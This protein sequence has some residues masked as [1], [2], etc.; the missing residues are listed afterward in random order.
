MRESTKLPRVYLAGKI[1][2]NDWRHDVVS[3]LRGAWGEDLVGGAALTD[4]EP[5]PVLA[6][7]VLNGRADYV[8]PYFVSCD[9]GCTHNARSHAVEGGC[10]TLAE[11][12][13]EY[14]N[15]VQIFSRCLLS[16]L[17]AD[18]VMGWINSPDCYGTLVE[19]GFAA[20]HGK[21]VVVGFDQNELGDLVDDFWFLQQLASNDGVAMFKHHGPADLLEA[22]IP[23]PAPVVELESEAERR[24]WSAYQELKPASLDGLVTQ[25]KALRY[26]LDFALPAQRIGIEIDGYAYHSDKE[27][28]TRDR[29]RQR[30]L[31]LAGWRI[32][33]FSG[34]EACDQ[35]QQCV[36]DAAAAVA[37]FASADPTPA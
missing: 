23:T 29:K 36:R 11:T 27:T 14:T 25:H 17:S 33:R 2:K 22:A 4:Q 1:G 30:E 35:P 8:G 32:V 12:R 37:A 26:R 16:I 34:K 18:L 13:N 28:F 31:E 6:G 7:A 3:G 10:V 9:H 24:F 15:K 5:W 20:A 21:P 19:L